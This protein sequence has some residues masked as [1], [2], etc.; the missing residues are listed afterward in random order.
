M[1]AKRRSLRGQTGAALCAAAGEN[2]TAIG[3]MHSL[4]EA[5]DL[6]TLALFRLVGTTH[7]FHC[8][9]LLIF[10]AARE[11]PRATRR[12]GNQHPSPQLIFRPAHRQV[13]SIIQRKKGSVN[14]KFAAGPGQ[15]FQNNGYGTNSL[16]RLSPKTAMPLF[17]SS[18]AATPLPGMTLPV[19]VPS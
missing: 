1:A 15:F 2:F 17:S 16:I 10:C 8:L 6:G 18:S 11:R 9:H 5:V 7:G 14:L 4:P 19:N 13:N 3:S 12:R